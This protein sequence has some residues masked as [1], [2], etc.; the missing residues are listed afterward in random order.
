MDEQNME[1]IDIEKH[2]ELFAYEMTEVVLKL[3][4]EFAVISGKDTQ[5]WKNRVDDNVLK[6]API[7][8]PVVKF[9]GISLNVCE[10]LITGAFPENTVLSFGFDK[11]SVLSA[12]A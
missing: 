9:D 12:I 5:Y 10:P 11:S 8:A 6:V 7:A 4:G 1:N 3:K 2:K